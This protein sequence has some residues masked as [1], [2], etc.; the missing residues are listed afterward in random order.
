MSLISVRQINAAQLQLAVQQYAS[1]DAFDANILAYLNSS[2]ALGPV[3]MT[4]TGNQTATGVKTFLNSPIVPYSGSTGAAPSRLYV[5]TQDLAIS[6]VLA[7]QS[8]TSASLVS[9]SGVLSAQ[10]VLV[11]GIL[12]TGISILSGYVNGA[13]GALSAV[14]VT[15]SATIPIAHFTGLGGTLIIHS[16]DYVLVSGAASAGGGSNTSVTG[17]AAI[18]APNF[19]GVGNVTLTYD[20]TYVKVSGASASSILVTGSAAINTPNFTGIGNVVVSYN[21]TYVLVSGIAGADATLSGYIENSFVHRYG[22]ESITGVKSFVSSPLVPNATITGQ[23]VNFGQLS[24]VSGVL[25]SLA[26]GTTNNYYITGTGVVT[27][28]NS[29]TITNT[30]SITSGNTTVFNTG[31]STNTFNNSGNINVTSS[32]TV[33]NNFN[34]AVNNVTNLSGITGNFVNIS[35]WYDQYNLATGLNSI[36]TF[37]GRSFTFTGYGLGTINSGTQGFFSGSFYQRT[38]TNTKT[39]FVDFSLNSGLYYYAAGG[40]NQEISGQNRV[41]LDIYRIGTGITGLSVGLFGVGY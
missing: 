33:T 25:S 38:P 6:G 37:V 24:G 17:S 23:A 12:A 5:D 15:G 40:F 7:G 10:T 11:S 26:G 41:G 14:R 13:S 27:V 28:L 20:G 30:Y 4:L 3:A 1:G 22:N 2:G 21:G 32:G 18:S 39:N 8:A 19:T 36:E 35:F 29:G 31:T 16:G 34:G 9:T